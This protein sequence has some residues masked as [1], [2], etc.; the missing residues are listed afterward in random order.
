M[1][2]LQIE[3]GTICN[4]LFNHNLQSFSIVHVFVAKSYETMVYTGFKE[5]EQILT[6]A[7]YQA[8]VL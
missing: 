5:R 1:Y 6:V 2:A 3:R 4:I 7:I 8:C